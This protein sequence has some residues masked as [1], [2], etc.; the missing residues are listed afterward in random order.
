MRL[1]RYVWRDDLRRE[2]VV[3]MRPIARGDEITVTYKR[4]YQVNMC[5]C[6]CVF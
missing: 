5:V 6:V 1:R 2:F 4:R 3:A